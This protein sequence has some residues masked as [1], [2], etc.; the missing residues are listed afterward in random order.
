MDEEGR[1]GAV[2]AALEVLVSA[3]LEPI[4][5]MVVRRVGDD[6]YEARAHDGCSTFRRS[7]DGT[8]WRFSVSSV[9]GRDP[10]ADQDPSRFAGVDVE[11]ANPFPERTANSYPNGY[12]LNELGTRPV[13]GP[14]GCPVRRANGSAVE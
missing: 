10:L 6:E 14:R 13:P 5:E 9:E 2:D 8:G 4:V 1:A 12:E 3:E 7:D 11:R